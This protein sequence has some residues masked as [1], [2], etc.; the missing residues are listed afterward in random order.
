MNA[1]TNDNTGFNGHC[2]LIE[3]DRIA[4]GLPINGPVRPVQAL[5]EEEE[6]K[7]TW[8]YVK[9]HDGCIV[10]CK[11]GMLMVNSMGEYASDTGSHLVTLTGHEVQ[12][13]RAAHELREYMPKA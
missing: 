6:K 5:I 3:R 11:Y 9:G 13:A 12:Q 8:E 10:H 1:N 7:N 2:Y 4:C